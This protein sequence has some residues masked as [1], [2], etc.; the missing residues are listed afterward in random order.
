MFRVA[1]AFVLLF[2]LPA[3]AGNPQERSRKWWLGTQAKELGLTADQSTTIDRLYEAAIPR[4]HT[5]MEDFQTAQRDLNKLI[6][7]DKTTETDVIRQLVQTQA[8]R[9]EFDRQ[10]TLMLFRFYQQLTPDQRVKVRAMFERREQERRE[11]RRG[12]PPARPPRKK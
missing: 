11:G 12:D 7:G 2:S 6:A 3:A 5:A 8:A 1:I 10:V 4:V 9:N